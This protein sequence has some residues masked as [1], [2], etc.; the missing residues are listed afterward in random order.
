MAER[1][2]NQLLSKQRESAITTIDDCLLFAGKLYKGLIELSN[3]K[4]PLDIRKGVIGM[5]NEKKGEVIKTSGKIYFLDIEKTKTGKPYL[6]ITESR[7]D[8]K[9]GNQIRNSVIVFRE[10][11]KEFSEAINSIAFLI[12]PDE[13]E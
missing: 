9:N 8:P 5:Y 4:H 10:S 11:I 12:K 2:E 13:R 1:G 7:K 3:R 6:K